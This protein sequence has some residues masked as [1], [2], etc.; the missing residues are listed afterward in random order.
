M[1]PSSPSLMP[2]A[3]KTKSAAAGISFSRRITKRGVSKIRNTVIIF[4]IFMIS[5]FLPPILAFWD[6]WNHKKR[7]IFSDKRVVCDIHQQI[8]LL[9]RGEDG[10]RFFGLFNMAHGLPSRIIDPSVLIK[11]FYKHF[12]FINGKIA[13]LDDPADFFPIRRYGSF[14]GINNRECQLP[15]L[16]IRPY[17]LPEAFRIRNVVKKIISHLKRKAE[18]AAVF[19]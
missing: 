1:K 19:R 6:G 7:S 13:V 4:G 5:V 14:Q 10:D 16:Q 3:V 2:A 18:V 11:H 8:S 12:K 9:R 15:F 17:R